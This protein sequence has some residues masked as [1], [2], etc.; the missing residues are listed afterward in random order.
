LQQRGI[1]ESRGISLLIFSVP[2]AFQL[3]QQFWQ[4][5]PFL[6]TVWRKA[7][8]VFA[9][10]LGIVDSFYTFYRYCVYSFVIGAL[11]VTLPSLASAQANDEKRPN[12]SR[13]FAAIAHNTA[14]HQ[15]ILFGGVNNGPN[16]GGQGPFFNDTWIWSEAGWKKLTPA[17]QPDP[18]FVAAMAYD[19]DRQ[20]VV[21]FGGNDQQSSRTVNTTWAHIREFPASPFPRRGTDVFYRDTW[22][23]NGTDWTQRNPAQAPSERAG[24][25]MAYD[26]ERK[27]VVLFGGFY[28]EKGL[29]ND[30]WVWNG[31][32][33]KKMNPV[34]IPPAR[35][36]AAMAYDPNRKQIVMFGGMDA[37]RT[38]AGHYSFGDTWLWDGTNWTKAELIGDLPEER[39]GAGFDYDPSQE[40]LVLFP[41]MWST[42]PELVCPRSTAGPGMEATGRSWPGRHLN[43]FLTRR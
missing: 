43:C 32:N 5:R 35:C 33:W 34:N 18:R 13:E 9:P 40:R 15:F 4:S 38:R 37:S 42:Q 3:W 22:V 27:Q 19:S 30:T 7:M 14:T 31:T 8:S 10:R 36:S 29:F 20:E 16:G 28:P 17:T 11:L 6:L 12:I 39:Q 2:S 1:E 21:L 23:S 41:G 25:A 26:A 24:H